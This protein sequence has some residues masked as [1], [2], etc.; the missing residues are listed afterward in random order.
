MLR[1][2]KLSAAEKKGLRIGSSRKEGAVQGGAAQAPGKVFS[3]K[4][5]HANTIEQA[6]GR[7]WCPLRGIECKARGQQIPDHL[8]AGF[9]K[10]KGAG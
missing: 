5:I 8:P 3:E 1:K 9:G 10:G 7:V 6:L 4:L 2:L